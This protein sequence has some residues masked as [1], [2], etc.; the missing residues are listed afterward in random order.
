MLFWLLLTGRFTFANFLLAA[1]LA[2]LIPLSVGRIR[3]EV[4]AVQKPLKFVSFIGLLLGDIVVSNII[5]ARQVLGSPR[6]LQPGFVSI[7]L[8]L[9]GA[10]PITILASTISLTPG[11]VSL[12]ISEDQTMLYV[13]A[14]HVTDEKVLIERIKQ[15]YEKPLKEIFEC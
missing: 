10:L 12:E 5:V 8:D 4:A 1:F 14:L 3:T 9:A 6:R 2:W 7:P 15:R 13:H 11:T